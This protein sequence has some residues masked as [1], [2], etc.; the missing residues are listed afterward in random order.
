MS[1]M[2]LGPRLF[3][4]FLLLFCLCCAYSQSLPPDLSAIPSGKGWKGDVRAFRPADVDGRP[5]VEC[6]GPGRHLVWI[7]NYDFKD[8]VI[9]FDAKGKSDPQSSFVGAA[10]RVQSEEIFDAVYLRPFNFR[11]SDPRKQSHAIQYVSEPDWPWEKLRAEKKGQFEN[12]LAPA[13]SGDS[14]FHVK[15]AVRQRKVSAWVNGVEQPSL[16]ITELG[17]HEGGSVGLLCIGYGLIS[18]L[19]IM[20]H[21]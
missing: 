8:G 21:K 13:P 4:G 2:L 6:S 12:S 17:F 20:P 18:N 3:A 14:W 16:A 10:F 19:R 1:R 7:E 15:L 5:A 11:S 9:E